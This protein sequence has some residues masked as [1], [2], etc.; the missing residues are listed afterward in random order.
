MTKILAAAGALVCVLIGVAILGS[1]AVLPPPAGSAT[2]GLAD[3]SV[4]PRASGDP[5]ASSDVGRRA[6]ATAATQLGVPY[7]FG[8]ATPGVGFDCSGLVW[9]A[10]H[11]A[12][13][14]LPRS[15]FDQADVG[16]VV[17]IDEL[18]PGDLVF[19][20]G[21][22]PARDLGHVS[23]YAGDGQVLTAPHTGTVITYRALDPTSVQKVRRVRES[24]G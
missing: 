21:G 22:D 10:Y 19:T 13:V 14:E 2:R 6:L 9:W 8:A 12:G 1:G 23:L 11:Q 15:T 4:P 17:G 18:Q 16:D 7:V 5:L 20:R 3:G 24:S